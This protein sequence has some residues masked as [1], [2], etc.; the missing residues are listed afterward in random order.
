VKKGRKEKETEERRQKKKEGRRTKGR[1]KVS[2]P[3]DSQTCS[4][5]T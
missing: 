4:K 2:K 5:E 1:T 3:V